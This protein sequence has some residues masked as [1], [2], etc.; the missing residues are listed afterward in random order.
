MT[1]VAVMGEIATLALLVWQVSGPG[2]ERI[3]LVALLTI[4]SVLV[5][6][7]SVRALVM[8]G[9]PAAQATAGPAR[10]KSLLGMAQT[11]ATL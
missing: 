4:G 3:V 1:L 5:A 10:P 6:A 11:S 2:G 8:F 7:Y 9:A